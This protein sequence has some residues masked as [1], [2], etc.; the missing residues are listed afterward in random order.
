MNKVVEGHY[1]Y[2]GF[3]IIKKGTMWSISIGGKVNLVPS[4]PKAKQFINSKNLTKVRYD[5]LRK[6]IVITHTTYTMD[7]DAKTIK[8]WL[9]ST[10]AP[11][12]TLLSVT[13]KGTMYNKKNYAINY[14][15][16]KE[17]I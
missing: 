14:D 13:L 9:R 6:G 4:L 8:D 7:R 2:G 11:D 12:E 10:L 17:V 3:D 1:R 15:C 16:R 5:I